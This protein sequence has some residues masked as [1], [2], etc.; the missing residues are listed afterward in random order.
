MVHRLQ[1]DPY[2]SGDEA[3]YFAESH[4]QP[5]RQAAACLQQKYYD[6]LKYEEMPK[7]SARRWVH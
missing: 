2:F 1:S 5:T 7:S 3:A 4:L 6:D